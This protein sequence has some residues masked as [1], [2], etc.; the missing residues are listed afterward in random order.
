MLQGIS[1]L[2]REEFLD[3]DYVYFSQKYC[4][5]LHSFTLQI[6]HIY[7]EQNLIFNRSHIWKEKVGFF[8]PEIWRSAFFTKTLYE[9]CMNYLKRNAL[10]LMVILETAIMPISSLKKEWKCFFKT[11]CIVCTDILNRILSMEDNLGGREL[12]YLSHKY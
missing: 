2:R 5:K 12:E 10:I 8:Q 3:R 1:Y 4:F 6:S 9:N 7:I 11:A